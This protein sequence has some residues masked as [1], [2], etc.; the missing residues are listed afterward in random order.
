LEV[1]KVKSCW[2]RYEDIVS[3]RVKWALYGIGANPRPRYYPLRYSYFVKNSNNKINNYDTVG[4]FSSKSK[5]LMTTVGNSIKSRLWSKI[6][7]DIQSGKE[8]YFG[9]FRVSKD[10]IRCDDKLGFF[11]HEIKEVKFCLSEDDYFLVEPKPE[12]KQKWDKESRELGSRY[13]DSEWV[14]NPHLLFEV[15]AMLKVPVNVDAVP[16]LADLKTI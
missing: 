6:V 3:V 16:E 5:I 11:I 12:F 13:V 14:D 4:D 8:V 2:Y 1:S 15:L 7:S 10:Y 9:D